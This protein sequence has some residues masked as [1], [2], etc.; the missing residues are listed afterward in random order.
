MKMFTIGLLA[1]IVATM[2]ITPATAQD[3]AKTTTPAVQLT[4]KEWKSVIGYFSSPQNKE[5]KVQFSVDAGMLVAKLLWNGNTIHLVPSSPLTFTSKEMEHDEP[6]RLT[7]HQDPSGGV[8]EVEVDK[9]GVWTR[10]KNYAPDPPKKEIPHTPEMIKPY[11]GLYQNPD[12]QTLFLR[13]TEKDNHLWLK[14]LWND[15]ELS[16]GP[17]SDTSFFSPAAPQFTMTFQKDDKGNVVGMTAFKRDKW[18]K[19]QPPHLT[20]AQIKPL[21]GI[22][23]SK[24]DPDNTI[25]LTG[26]GNQLTLTQ[27]WDKKEIVLDAIADDYFYNQKDSY[28]LVVL[29][30]PNG[31]ITSIIVLTTNT[32]IKKETN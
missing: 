10:E 29:K 1:I 19:K 5:M 17:L 32:F 25:R 7:F 13:L 24:D 6:I 11:I 31:K 30:D 9:N 4:E 2:A 20:D 15:V 28:P 16:F 21:L 18:V 26:K 23:F 22:Y 12:N 27:L 3:T 14:Q 8:N